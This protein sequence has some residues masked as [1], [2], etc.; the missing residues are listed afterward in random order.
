VKVMVTSTFHLAILSLQ[1]MLIVRRVAC[2]SV[3]PDLVRR[4]PNEVRVISL[5]EPR[6]DSSL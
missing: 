4:A 2:M 3:R 5:S 6:F 1:D